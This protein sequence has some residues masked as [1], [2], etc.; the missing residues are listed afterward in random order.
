MTSQSPR[1]YLYKITFEEV[2]YYYY[3]IKKEKYYN[4]EYWGSPYTHKWIWE[5]YT[6][7]KQILELFDYSDDGYIEAQRIE[8][9]IIKPLY[10]ID[11]WCLNENCGGIISLEIN[12]K[13]GKIMG[14]RTKE[15]K[16]GLFGRSKEKIIK[17]ARKAGAV[18]AK[19][20]KELGRGIFSLT[21][22]ERS[23]T[24][25]K[26]KKLKLGIHG[27]TTEQRSEN[28]KKGGNKNVETGHIQK[29]GKIMGQRTKENKT[30][31][32]ART[33]EQRIADGIKGGNKAYE[34][35]VGVHARTKEQRI[36]DGI[37]GGS[38]SGKINFKNKTGIFSLTKEER[39]E[40]VK[41]TNSQ[42][43]MC[44]ETGYITTPGP[45]TRYQRAR[46]IDTSKRVKVS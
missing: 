36:A 3:G 12:R 33:K 10:N 30:G 35:R 20:N 14:Q 13:T 8:K 22:E 15:N 25:K 4:Q 16:T 18:S 9:R 6:P 17:D 41:K 37:K 40:V 28:S 34:M 24:G 2:P 32:Y 27:L 42:K 7:K 45:L 5:F 29:L 26:N 38:I 19:R 23:E 1:I 46:E 44:L 21:K 43:W 11:K 31:V 39:S